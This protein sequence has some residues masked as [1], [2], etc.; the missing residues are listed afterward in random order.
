[1]VPRGGRNKGVKDNLLHERA[2]NTVNLQRLVS[3]LSLLWKF[4]NN[5]YVCLKIISK[6]KFKQTNLKKRHSNLDIHFHIAR[7]SGQ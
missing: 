5:E 3:Y 6:I 1:M 7:Q 4:N 2:N